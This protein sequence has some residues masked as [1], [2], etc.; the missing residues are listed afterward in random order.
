[1]INYEVIIDN[2][3]IGVASD[4]NF[5]YYNSR[6]KYVLPSTIQNAQFISLTSG[7]Y[8]ADWMNEVPS[9][10]TQYKI[11]TVIEITEKEAEIL[12][13][14]SD[15]QIT[16]PLEYKSPS[17][18]SQ[19]SVAPEEDNITPSRLKFIKNA[20]IIELSQICN[21]TI[22]SGVDV[23]ML[24]GQTHHF[25][26]TTQD[27]LNLISLQAM[28]DQGLEQIPYHAD[29][30]LCKFYTP[31]EIKMIIAEATKWKTYHT[32]Y[33]NALKNYVNSLDDVHQIAEIQYGIELPE[34]YQSDVLKTLHD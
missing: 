13:S 30:E 9:E 2:K 18:T 28:V 19:P 10:Y 17:Y 7:L 6:S 31:V 32:T 16:I 24:D 25:S 34:E 1:M 26:L 21:Q 5:K 15:N 3:I 4:N 33:Y 12:I 27:Q 20:K 22:E 11:A 8:H 14:A 29:G 23:G